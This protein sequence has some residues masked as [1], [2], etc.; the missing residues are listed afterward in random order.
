MRSIFVA[1]WFFSIGCAT[2]TDGLFSVAFDAGTKVAQVSVLDASA[3]DNRTLIDAT[4][5]VDGEVAVDQS[6]IDLVSVD[7]EPID[8][9][10]IDSVSVDVR[11]ID[12]S[13]INCIQRVI[14]NGY[15]SCAPSDPYYTSCAACTLD[16]DPQAAASCKAQIDCLLKHPVCDSVCYTKCVPTTGEIAN[17]CVYRIVTASCGEQLWHP[18]AVWTC[19]KAL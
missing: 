15:A 5:L 19:K 2:E 11:S 7:V 3:I 8:T 12:A 1:F 13:P 10:P 6:G 4:I 16:H 14:D 18:G 17:V 9:S